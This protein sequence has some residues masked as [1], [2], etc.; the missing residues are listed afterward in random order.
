MDLKA[1]FRLENYWVQPYQD[2]LENTM[3]LRSFFTKEKD[4]QA[5]RSGDSRKHRHERQLNRNSNPPSVIVSAIKT[6]ATEKIVS[7]V[8]IRFAY[9]CAHLDLQGMSA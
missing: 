3:E 4:V 7:A 1:P 8:G 6:G 2:S 9:S 5:T